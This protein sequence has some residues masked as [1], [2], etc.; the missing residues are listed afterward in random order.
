[1]LKRNETK[2][3]SY[4]QDEEERS[5]RKGH[6]CDLLHRCMRGESGRIR[7]KI[8]CRIFRVY[9]RSGQ[10]L[11]RDTEETG[12]NNAKAPRASA[13]N[14]LPLAA[15]KQKYWTLLGLPV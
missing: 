10:K 13:S 7:C 9:R 4:E 8:R 5:A 12:G 14:I 11:A 15:A 6:L 3:I 1:M 2:N